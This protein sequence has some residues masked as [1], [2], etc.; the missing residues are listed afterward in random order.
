MKVTLTDATSGQYT[1]EQLHAVN[2]PLGD[3]E[4]NL[5]FTVNYQVKD[6]DGDTANGTMV[7][8][9]DDD[10]PVIGAPQHEYADEGN[11]PNDAY[12]NNNGD[13]ANSV[14]RFGGLNIQWGADNYDG[15][16]STA[17]DRSVVFGSSIATGTP[18]TY[19]PSG[20]SAPVALTSD[21]H[22]IYFVRSPTP[23]SS[24][25]P[26]P[27]VASGWIPTETSP[28]VRTCST[29]ACRATAMA[30]TSSP[31]PA[32]SIIRPAPRKHGRHRARL[33]RDQL[34]WRSGLVRVHRLDR[35]RRAGGARGI[36]HDP[37]R[38]GRH[39]YRAVDGQ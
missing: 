33:R 15:D 9:V 21:G 27:V 22:P 4:N 13:A 18:V 26:T 12:D 14:V 30:A 7:I 17:F 37:C 34:R 3:N 6:G 25:S 20:G 5:E 11:L 24:R 39:R 23:S 32:M 10:T 8:N 38:R 19:I 36:E 35:R 29:C 2:H 28:Q 16:G 1:V 31:C